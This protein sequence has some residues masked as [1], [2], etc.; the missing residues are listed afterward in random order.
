MSVTLASKIIDLVAF[1]LKVYE[2]SL[3]LVMVDHA[4]S[5]CAATIVSNK[6]PSSTLKGI[7]LSWITIF[8]APNQFL[9]DN[10]GE[11]NNSE[12]RVRRA[13]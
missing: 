12:M 6:R 5:F 13:F 1:D 3:F 9:S 4:T 2:R 7:L 11:F 8:G 10:G